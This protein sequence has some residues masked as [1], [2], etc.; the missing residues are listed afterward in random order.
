[1]IRLF[2]ALLR[3]AQ[4]Q[5]R[6]QF[7][8]L[9]ILIIVSG[10]LEMA[11]LA[12]MALFVTSL[13][14]LD[15]VLNAHYVQMFLWT[16]G[17]SPHPEPSRFFMGL[18]LGCLGLVMF[19]NVV[20]AAHSYCTARFDGA[21]NADYGHR[22]LMGVLELPYEWVTSRNSADILQTIAWRQYVG[23]LATHLMTIFGECIVSLLL[24]VTLFTLQPIATFCAVAALG[25]LG[26]VS[27]AL[28]KGRVDTLA[29]Q[30]AALLLDVSRLFMKSVQGFRDVKLFDCVPQTLE[31][32]DCI[33]AQFVR[34]QASQR[35]YERGA[36]WIL[37]T[38]GL[39]GLILGSLAMFVALDMSSAKVMGMLAL[40]A[41]SAWRILPA[42]YRIV[43]VL[44]SIRGYL[45]FLERLLAFSTE[46]DI[47]NNRKKGRG[48]QRELPRLAHTID[49]Q[50]ICFTYAGTQD[51]ALS[52][53]SF[54]ISK[55]QTVGIIGPSG[56][57]KSTLADIL[58]GLLEPQT[59]A[60]FIDG[61][62]LDQDT[63]GS[64]MRQVGFVPQTPYLFDASL[65]EN[66]AFTLDAKT[67]HQ[68]RINACVVQ[69]GISEFLGDLDNGVMTH[70]GERG[71]RLS[72]GQAQRIA[73]ARAL[74]R[75]P[76]VLI[77]DEATSALDEKNERTIRDTITAL[78]GDRT[79]VII[80]HR[81][82]TVKD[83]DILVW[84]EQ[85]KVVACGP[86]NVVLPRYAQKTNTPNTPN[87][88]HCNASP[89]AQRKP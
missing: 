50:N 8:L 46:I 5:R 20:V 58:I 41:V 61:V 40:L 2:F 56:A 43:A 68:D 17:A 15:E 10:L 36:V 78:R 4:Q 32:I 76:E 33:L 12:S 54:S 66:I 42:M 1:M 14:S 16:I 88:P 25:L 84:I 27:Y 71:V 65:L 82:S 30:T 13:T 19:K 83:C 72:G 26:F 9:A 34:T 11:T 59:G 81:L 89:T 55:G 28:V 57:G 39:G 51:R 75:N 67:A 44:S 87:A 35:V 73:I 69:A 74:F 7:W 80:A 45:P 24:F 48:Q 29:Q 62:L 49:I 85:G 53:V 23:T 63:R 18:G 86:P 31:Q 64:W 47:A 77:F 21:L 6:T 52:D 38:L 22:L 60:V 70:I 79:L 37:E 3:G